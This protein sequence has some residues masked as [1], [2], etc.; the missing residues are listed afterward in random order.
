MIA[1]MPVIC[2]NTAS[3][4]PTRSGRRHRASNTSRHEARAPPWP[5]V[6]KLASVS[7]LTFRIAEIASARRPFASN[8]RGDSGATRATPSNA[9]PSAAEPPSIQRQASLWASQPSTK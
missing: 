3:P 4:T 5:A 6:F 1:L 9:N 7:G 8:Q 2:W